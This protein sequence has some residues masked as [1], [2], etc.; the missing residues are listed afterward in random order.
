[1]IFC[2]VGLTKPE[3]Q[4]YTRCMGIFIVLI[5]LIL[6]FGTAAYASIQ[7]APYVPTRREEKARM[8]KLA[9]IKP[10]ET[11][12]D[13]GSGTGQLVIGAVRQYGARGIGY[14]IS[15]LPFFIAFIW[16]LMLWRL[17]ISFR[18]KN[19]FSADLS[20]ANVILCFLTPAAMPRLE[21]KLLAELKPGSRVVSMAF[22]I[23]GLPLAE[24]SKPD[25]HA[26]PIFLY[27]I[28]E[29]SVR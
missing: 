4:A 15:I 25:E 17:P 26:T 29:R 28:P 6:L 11:V 22:Q 10:G 14:E 19:F 12:I 21:K 2:Q 24:K 1:M 9:G 18:F 20:K 16:R 7:A 23:R 3:K 13:L 27:R 5:I 8:L